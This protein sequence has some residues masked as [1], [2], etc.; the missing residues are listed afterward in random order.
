MLQNLIDRVGKT[1]VKHSINFIQHDMFQLAQVQS[2]SL[3]KICYPTRCSNDNINSRP[4]LGLCDDNVTQ[5]HV[6]LETQLQ[7]TLSKIQYQ[8]HM[9]TTSAATAEIVCDVDVGAHSLI[10]N[11]T[12]GQCA[13]YVH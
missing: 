13:T 10:Y 8:Q 2:S 1:H 3:Q 11:R 4:D 7:K 12:Q 5:D 9:H 6:R